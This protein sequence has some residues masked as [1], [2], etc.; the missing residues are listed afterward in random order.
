MKKI[1]LIDGYGFVFR[2]FHSLPEMS[3]N[4]GT[5]VGAVF[6]F[7]QMLIKLLASLEVSHLAVIFDSG[8]KT[9]RH[10][11]YPQYKANRPPCPESL[12]PQFSIVRE[13]VDALNI[14]VL[15]KKGFE[16]DDIIATMVKKFRKED[17]EVVIVSSDKDLM[18][19]IDNS[20][21]LFDAM[22]NKI[23]SFNEVHEKFGVED[24]QK[25]LDVLALIGDSS[26]NIPGVK[27]IGIK[28]ASELINNFSDL[29][30][31]YQNLAQI[32]QEKRRLTLKDHKEEAFLSKKLIT[33]DDN[34]EI[35]GDLAD[36][37]VQKID[38][39]KLI[40]FLEKQGFKSL[41]YRVKK[42]FNI[43]SLSV[44]S[45]SADSD[46][47]NL[48]EN[49]S[50]A[51]SSQSPTQDQQSFNKI[52]IN[53]IYV[54]DDLHQK[55]QEKGCVVI[56]YII[57]ND[58]FTFITLS[59]KSINDKINEIYF[60]HLSNSS[61]DHN[62]PKDLFTSPERTPNSFELNIKNFDKILSDNSVRKVFYDG[63]KFLHYYQNY[64]LIHKLNVDLDEIV[65]DDLKLMNYL[66]NSSTNSLLRELIDV[67]IDI[68]IEETGYGEVIDKIASENYQ[69]NFET[70]DKKIECY[71]LINHAI[72]KLY[73]ALASKI[74]NLNL[75]HIYLKIELPLLKILS[76]MENCGIKI[77]HHKLINLSQDLS[78][79]I[80][81]LTQEIYKISGI[82]FNIAS[83]QQLADVLFNKMHLHSNVKSK[84][85]KALSTNAKVLEDL[86]S[87]GHEIVEKILD[88]RKFSKLKSTYCDALPKLISPYT[89]RVHSTFSSTATLT[90][91]LNSSNPNLQN[92][93]IKTDEGKKIRSCFIADKNKVLISADY[94]QI[95]LRIMAHLAKIP[96]LIEAF[97]LDKDIHKITAAQIFG[98]E[99]QLVDEKMRSKAKA[100]NFGIIYGIS[101]FG[102]SEQLKISRADAKNYIEAYFEKY[103]GIKEFMT[104]TINFARENGYVNTI[105]NRKCFIRDIN[106]KNPIILKEAER[107]A[108]NA[109]IQGSCADIIKKAMIAIDRQ[110][111]AHNLQAKL[112]LQIHDELIVEAT[113][114]EVETVKKILIKEM[115]T[116]YK[117]DVA[118]KIDINVSNSLIKN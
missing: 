76:K 31:L 29:E 44:N 107:Q 51:S 84:K 97:E 66:T 16:A 100:I 59:P 25:I 102:L 112:L 117:L 80:T 14:K 62:L 108:I 49:S 90:G 39:T 28:T 52:A 77:D 58:N 86:A 13:C 30:N 113:D 92:I 106:N 67:N 26:D 38:P 8:G 74:T 54:L 69:E 34:V 18:Q 63:K 10:D 17:F 20:T 48:H 12:V 115:S 75:Y 104:R 11:I 79:K 24:P 45:A 55:I 37:K 22:K 81:Q 111:L 114:H 41:V 60:G 61:F 47:E 73:E 4:D 64:H 15:E 19:L 6:G 56:D 1:A 46:V 98:V 110:F 101:S 7:T 57:Q 50:K 105:A 68:N 109:P 40:T 35:A 93:P 43:D 71:C 82:E 42:E 27:G 2:A 32:K 36:F 118:L 91:R 88:F 53:N 33:L 85:T 9:F 95:E 116:S 103:R 83:S 87:E 96:T 94:S 99:E 78:K 72:S 65:F 3:R 5:P 23:L 70:I 21:Y 89:H